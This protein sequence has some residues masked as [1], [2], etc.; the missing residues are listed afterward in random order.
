[1]TANP[2]LDA[3]Q[4]DDPKCQ[5]WQALLE[6]RRRNGASLFTDEAE[7]L[8]AFADYKDL[9]HS[10]PYPRIKSFAEEDRTVDHPRMLT[11]PGFRSYLSMSS[12]QWTRWLENQD[13]PLHEAAH[14]INSQIRAQALEMAAQ[15]AV[16]QHLV[17]RMLQ[18]EFAEHTKTEVA[19][20]RAPKHAFRSI[21]RGLDATLE[22]A[23]DAADAD[24]KP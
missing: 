18:E 16:P 7:F 20:D 11:A 10:N 13:H 22:T 8:Q 23:E 15:E 19:V 12:I 1:M 6:T 5:E 2:S 17:I 24:A 4:T 21:L 3:L 14:R 9:V